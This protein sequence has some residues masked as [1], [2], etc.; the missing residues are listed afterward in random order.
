MEKHAPTL[1]QW[2]KTRASVCFCGN[3][4]RIA[5]DMDA[6]L[7]TILERAGK[8][9]AEQATAYLHNSPPTAGT[10]AISTTRDA[11]DL[12]QSPLIFRSPHYP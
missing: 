10:A 8:R 9:T 7:H 5:T 12:S 2:L 11:D 6:A 1:W 4:A 3:A